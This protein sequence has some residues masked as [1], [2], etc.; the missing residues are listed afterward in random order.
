MM[1]RIYLLEHH[2][3]PHLQFKKKEYSFLHKYLF[4]YES[5]YAMA[6][7]KFLYLFKILAWGEITISPRVTSA[8]DDFTEKKTDFAHI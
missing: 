2:R 6:I 3:I 7:D 1:P 5:I 8:H 4:L